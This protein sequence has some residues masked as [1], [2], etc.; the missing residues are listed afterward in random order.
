MTT[1]YY[2]YQILQNTEVFLPSTLEE[3]FL[4][5]WPNNIYIYKKKCLV[6]H[7]FYSQTFSLICK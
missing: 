1:D 7:L 6:G 4:Q 3:A 5:G 2:Y